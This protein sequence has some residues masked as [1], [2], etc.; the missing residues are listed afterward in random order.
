MPKYTRTI[1]QQVELPDLGLTV[2][3]GDVVELPADFF[4]DSDHAVASGFTPTPSAKSTSAVTAS[5]TPAL[6]EGE[7]NADSK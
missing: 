5:A 2:N 3:F 4:T 1:D 7:V 6:P